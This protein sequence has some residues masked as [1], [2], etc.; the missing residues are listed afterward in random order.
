MV[1]EVTWCP[2]GRGA[3]SSLGNN[4]LLFIYD[5]SPKMWYVLLKSPSAVAGQCVVSLHLQAA[6]FLSSRISSYEL[7]ISGHQFHRVTRKKKKK[8]YS[9]NKAPQNDLKWLLSAFDIL[10]TWTAFETFLFST[11][12]CTYMRLVILHPSWGCWNGIYT[13]IKTPHFYCY[14]FSDVSCKI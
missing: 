11:E 12:A 2:T 6:V 7:K 14:C 13:T 3:Q 8:S 10:P 1:F 5:L 4:F 9:L